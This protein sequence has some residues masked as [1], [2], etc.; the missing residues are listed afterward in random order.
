VEG[1]S[2]SEIGEMLHISEGA[3]KNRLFEAKRELRRQLTAER[4]AARKATP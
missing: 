4:G 1:F 2:H 3:S